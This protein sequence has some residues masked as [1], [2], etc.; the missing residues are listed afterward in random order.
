MLGLRRN[1]LV[2]F[3]EQWLEDLF[4]EFCLFVI[5]CG[6]VLVCVCV[7]MYVGVVCVCLCVCVCVCVHV[8]VH[9]RIRICVFGP[10]Y[11]SV[12]C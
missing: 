6:Y 11:D 1:K 10:V 12:L 9:A 3:L 5:S 4:L 2:L 8:H 7:C